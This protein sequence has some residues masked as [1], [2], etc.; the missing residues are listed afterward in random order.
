MGLSTSPHYI[1]YVF[2]AK[3]PAVIVLVI[4]PLPPTVIVSLTDMASDLVN[5]PSSFSDVIESRFTPIPFVTVI[6]PAT[7]IPLLND[8][9]PPLPT[10]I[11]IPLF[12]VIELTFIAG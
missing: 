6:V 12:A 5:I 9:I 7:S 11:P 10:Y 8:F 2:R 1:P 4:I 3:L